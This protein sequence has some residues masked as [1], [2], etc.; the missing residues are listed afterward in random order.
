MVQ[1]VIHVLPAAM[2]DIANRPL[3]GLATDALA[4]LFCFCGYDSPPSRPPS[5]RARN[6]STAR[7]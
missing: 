5:R 1:I 2:A 6:R 3:E 4:G 7:M